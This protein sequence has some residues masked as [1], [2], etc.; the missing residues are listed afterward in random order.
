MSGR[1]EEYLSAS[2]CV[3]NAAFHP[4]LDPRHAAIEQIAANL[5]EGV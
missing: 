4:E 1:T 5:R 2:P 3:K